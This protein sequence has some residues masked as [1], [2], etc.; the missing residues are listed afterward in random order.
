M[1]GNII[2]VVWLLGRQHYDDNRYETVPVVSIIRKKWNSDGYSVC[3]A[4]LVRGHL[5]LYDSLQSQ[6]QAQ[7]HRLPGYRVIPFIL[8]HILL[9]INHQIIAS[10]SD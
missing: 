4:E 10:L 6:R 8:L 5:H 7:N 9:V 1:R 2:R 3:W